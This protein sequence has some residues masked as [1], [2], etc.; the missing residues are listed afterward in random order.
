MASGLVVL[1]YDYASGRPWI[2]NGVNGFLAPL[3]DR[4]AF[5][6]MAHRALAARCEWPETRAAG[7]ETTALMP[8]D[9]VVD[10]FE[11]SLEGAPDCGGAANDNSGMTPAETRSHLSVRPKTPPIR[12]YIRATNATAR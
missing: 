8:W 10:S 3:D 5:R 2:R 11:A 1:T 6:R 12:G 7:R 9:P 4:P